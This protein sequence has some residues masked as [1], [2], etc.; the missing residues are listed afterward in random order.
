MKLQDQ[1]CLMGVRGCIEMRMK[2]LDEK[3]LKML[4]ALFGLLVLMDVV[5]ILSVKDYRNVYGATNQ[6]SDSLWRI[7]PDCL[8]MIFHALAYFK[9]ARIYSPRFLLGHGICFGL[10]G[11]AL[12]LPWGGFFFAPFSPIGLPYLV[13]IGWLPHGDFI[14]LFI[15]IVFIVFNLY[16]IRTALG[17]KTIV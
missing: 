8:I 17:A 16:L 10:I 11:F 13:A 1:I 7:I 5:V 3:Y 4:F 15:A 12:C 6:L 14:A 2:T 9:S